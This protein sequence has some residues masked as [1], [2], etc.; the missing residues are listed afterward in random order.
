MNKVTAKFET[1]YSIFC[2]VTHEIVQ[3]RESLLLSR[4]WNLDLNFDTDLITR[5]RGPAAVTLHSSLILALDPGLDHQDP[6]IQSEPN[7]DNLDD[8]LRYD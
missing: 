5:F 3:D 7:L 2:L 4:N 6:H 1:K 8:N